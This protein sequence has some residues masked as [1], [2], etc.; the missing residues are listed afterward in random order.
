M[1]TVLDLKWHEEAGGFESGSYRIEP[2]RGH[3]RYN[4]QLSVQAPSDGHGWPRWPPIPTTHRTLRGAYAQARQL[5]HTRIRR[6]RVIHHSI[7]GALWMLLFLVLYTQVQSL[8][9]FML[10]LAFLAAA[11]RSLAAAAVLAIGGLSGSTVGDPPTA[12][13]RRVDGAIAA[14]VTRLRPRSYEEA[15]AEPRVRALSPLPPD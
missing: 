2:L 3:P 9:M 6:T 5:E 10:T 7:V 12:H 15:P 4:W 11:L 1:R 14:A 13:E 8:L